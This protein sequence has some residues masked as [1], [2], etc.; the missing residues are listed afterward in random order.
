MIERLHRYRI[1][2]SKIAELGITAYMLSFGTSMIDTIWA[3]YLY[4]F[5]HNASTVGFVSALFTGAMFFSLLALIPFIERI[6]ESRAFK[7]I[8]FINGLIYLAFAIN[9]NIIL[10]II[11]TFAN[12]IL[13]NL[14]R[15]S[16]GILVRDESSIKNLSKNEGLIY[17]LSN[18]S[19]VIG[20]LVAGFIAEKYSINVVF[21]LAFLFFMITTFMLFFVKFRKSHIPKTTHINII[22]NFINFFRNWKRTTAY[23][24]TMGVKI[25]WSF[26]Y[27]FIPIEIINRGYGMVD[28]GFFLFII[29]FP[30]IFFEYASGDFV[31]KAGHKL[32]Y[33]YGYFILTILSLVLL[34]TDSMILLI[35]LLFLA[36]FIFSFL[37]P[38]QESFFFKC[39][40]KKDEDL[41]YPAFLTT[42]SIGSTFTKIC[43]AAILLILPFN[44]V[45]LF[46]AIVM[47]S[48]F[49]IALNISE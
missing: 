46:M 45:F 20:P 18:I 40:K 26:I 19:Y 3:L 44:F 49:V 25:W 14:R 9:K 12:V 7:Y 4:S 15:V 29:A 2:I 39:I 17:N 22:K 24:M 36:S 8:I 33:I 28:V 21:A 30:L 38:M 10:L 48:M 42:T 16:Y 43:I 32:F 5:F 1:H 13:L 11:L 34:Y 23:F 27:I 35:F 47:F 37:E 6:D 41:Y 31:S